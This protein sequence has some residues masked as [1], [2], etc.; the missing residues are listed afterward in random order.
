MNILSEDEITYLLQICQLKYPAAYPVLYLSLSTGASVPELLGLTW[1]R[2]NFE[3]N[4]I[5][6][7]Y[8]LYERRLVVN[9][10]GTAARTLKIDNK[11]S[12]ILQKKLKK[13]NPVPSDFVFKL[14][15][16]KSP[17]QYFER[18]VLRGL[19]IQLGIQRLFPSDLQH[20]FAN[21]CLKQNIP[22]TFIQKSLGYYSLAN[23]V[24]IYK[25]LIENQGKEYYNPLDEIYNKTGLE[26]A[27]K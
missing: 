26:N 18:V 7:K 6:L 10:G 3:D 24:K 17:Q 5:F 21:L 14:N 9:K 13:T 4:T 20:N 23:F 22:V 19:S 25:N 2:I 1:D 12:G 16:P 11:I 27:E 15:S 8:F